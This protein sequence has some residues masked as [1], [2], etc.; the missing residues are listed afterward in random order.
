MQLIVYL[1]QFYVLKHEKDS[2]FILYNFIF[3]LKCI[4]SISDIGCFSKWPHLDSDLA[5][6]AACNRLTI[7]H[8]RWEHQ[9]DVWNERQKTWQMW[10]LLHF[11]LTHANFWNCKFQQ[12]LLFPLHLKKCNYKQIALYSY[13]LL[14]QSIPSKE[15]FSIEN[16]HPEVTHSIVRLHDNFKLIHECLK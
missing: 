6:C 13:L 16:G 12:R 9:I 15:I 3:T 14:L 8:R 4:Y 11:L 7:L 10:L 2:N 1:V 5:L